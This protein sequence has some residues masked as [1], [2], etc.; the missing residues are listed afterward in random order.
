[1]CTSYTDLIE[2]AKGVIRLSLE[3]AT[4]R[5]ALALTCRHEAQFAVKP[6][7]WRKVTKFA[8]LFP[9]EA[10]YREKD[11]A[12]A[13]ATCIRA[14]MQGD[15]ATLDIA[16]ATV[17]M[18]GEWQ[19]EAV[20]GD[21]TER[22]RRAWAAHYQ[23]TSHPVLLP[24]D[25]YQ[26]TSNPFPFPPDERALLDAYLPNLLT[27]LPTEA[28]RVGPPC[29]AT[30]NEALIVEDNLALVGR[31]APQ[32]LPT[33]VIRQWALEHGSGVDCYLALRPATKF[34]SLERVFAKN[35][36]W[37]HIGRLLSIF[38][39][40]SLSKMLDLLR[41]ARSGAYQLGW[42]RRR[43]CDEEE[44]VLAFRASAQGRTHGGTDRFANVADAN[45]LRELLVWLKETH[46]PSR[47]L[48]CRSPGCL[49]VSGEELCYC[50]AHAVK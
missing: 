29:N 14:Y 19:D 17:R 21:L 30:F 7:G 5:L 26:A 15:L 25:H 34:P 31:F 4:A 44:A 49:F 42:S 32:K 12:E 9:T 43:E 41:T 48:L 28:R 23:A 35:R 45:A 33:S 24:P 27:Q 50:E 47:N 6:D 20:L 1:M 11:F 10:L 46:E 16:L 8:N 40:A 13:R 3:W 18:S 22:M 39:P 2:D 36:P 37:P 38:A